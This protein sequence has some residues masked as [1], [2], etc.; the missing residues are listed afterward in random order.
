MLGLSSPCHLGMIKDASPVA[1]LMETMLSMSETCSSPALASQVW[2]SVP[3]GAHRS[4]APGSGQSPDV[5]SAPTA[6]V[7]PWVPVVAALGLWASWPLRIILLCH[8]Y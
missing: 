4:R 5:P 3:C 6:E 8:C 2:R 1:G 7:G